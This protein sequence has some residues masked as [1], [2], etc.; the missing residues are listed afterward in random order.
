MIDY[1]GLRTKRERDTF[2]SE[3]WRDFSD[4]HLFSLS[5]KG[6]LNDINT[7]FYK[8]LEDTKIEKI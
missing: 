4:A 6:P 1:I 8:Y 2:E 7:S 5:V 3:K